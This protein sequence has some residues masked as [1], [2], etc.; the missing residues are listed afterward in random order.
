MCTSAYALPKSPAEHV[1]SYS[2][3]FT[4]YLK[5]IRLWFL[6]DFVDTHPVTLA[7]CFSKEYAGHHCQT[8]TMIP[9]TRTRPAQ[10][11]RLEE[12]PESAVSASFISARRC[13]VYCAN[14]HLG[15]AGA[16]VR[17]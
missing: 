10:T 2:W 12:S 16:F 4:T 17:R 7:G 6:G 11:S 5:S 15:H 1:P 8:K 3:P 14:G 9:T 13:L